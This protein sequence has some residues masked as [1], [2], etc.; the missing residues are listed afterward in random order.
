MLKGADWE[1]MDVQ[2]ILPDKLD[3][4][5]DYVSRRTVWSDP[6]VLVRTITVVVW[7]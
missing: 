2:R 4:E 1:Q 5:L 3:I 7:P 6:A